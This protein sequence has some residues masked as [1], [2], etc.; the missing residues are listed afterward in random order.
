M[1]YVVVLEKADQNYAAYVPDL[2]GCVAAAESKAKV[3]DLIRE[4][5]RFHLQGLQEQGL[6]IPEPVATSEMIKV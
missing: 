1:N 5:I 6:P 2:P 3:I 4:A